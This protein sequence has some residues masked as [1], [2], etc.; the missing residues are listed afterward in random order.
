VFADSQVKTSFAA[1]G[2]RRE[3]SCM[4]GRP[5]EDLSKLSIKITWGGCC[6]VPDW[7]PKKRKG[8]RVIS[9]TAS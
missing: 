6:T 5:A 9:R 2:E 7:N 4:V 1:L 3:D 8:R